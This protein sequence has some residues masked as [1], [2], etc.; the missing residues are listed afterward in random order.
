MFS[1]GFFVRVVKSRDCVVKSQGSMPFQ[2]FIVSEIENTFSGAQK[3]QAVG[4]LTHGCHL[5]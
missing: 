5:C 3:G 1:K 4:T 2:V